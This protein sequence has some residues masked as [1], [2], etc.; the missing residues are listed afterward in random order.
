M[1]ETHR[2]PQ[3][4]SETKVEPVN[5]FNVAVFSV[6]CV[7]EECDYEGPYARN[8]QIAECLHNDQCVKIAR[9]NLSVASTDELV[10]E[11]NRRDDAGIEVQ[12]CGNCYHA[13]RCSWLLGGSYDPKHTS[14]DFE[15]SRFIFDPNGAPS[16][17][18]QLRKARDAERL[19]TMQSIEIMKENGE[20]EDTLREMREKMEMLCDENDA[21][22]SEMEVV[23][24]AYNQAARILVEVGVWKPVED[25]D[26]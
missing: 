26:K 17:R 10:R 5:T 7:S 14:C 12:R 15:P 16:L 11:L 24:E 22:N 13:S 25:E 20:L 4:G 8:A 2:C 3:C 6:S 23:N 21:L 1:G 18:D 19:A 9:R